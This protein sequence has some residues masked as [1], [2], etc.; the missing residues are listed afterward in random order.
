MTTAK[1]AREQ[2]KNV[3]AKIGTKMRCL[4]TKSAYGSHGFRFDPKLQHSVGDLID[5][6]IDGKSEVVDV[7]KES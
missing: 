2:A 7:I 1:E 6:G 4:I 3:I 5:D